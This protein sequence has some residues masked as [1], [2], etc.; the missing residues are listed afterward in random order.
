MINLLN[1]YSSLSKDFHQSLIKAG[2]SYPTFVCQ[3]DGFLP[4]DVQSI[5]QLWID[6]PLEGER[7]YFN[8]LAVPEFWEISA[9][10][11]SGE[12]IDY[13]KKRGR[14]HF[15]KITENR[16]IERVEWF[17]EQGKVRWIDGY[18]KQ[19]IRYKQTVLTKD[20]RM[21]MTTYFDSNGR[22][23]IIYNHHTKTYILMEEHGIQLF[24]TEID[25][26]I[27]TLRAHNV[28]LSNIIYNTLALPFLVVLHSKETKES[29]LIWQEDTRD[30]VPGNMQMILNGSTSTKQ[31]VV[32][33][34][35]YADHLKAL[36]SS[37]SDIPIYDLGYIYS[38][39][40][41]EH[42][43]NEAIIATNS[44]QILHLEEIVQRLPQLKIHV[45]ALTE[46]SAKLTNLN[47]YENIQL[48]PNASMQKI[49]NLY[50]KVGWLLDLNYGNEI[51][52]AVR[53]AFDYQMVIVSFDETTH[54]Q[55]FMY[56]N[57]IFQRTQLDEMIQL[58]KMSF[59]NPE[60]HSKLLV[61]Q[62]L[63]A[64]SVTKSDYVEIFK[65]IEGYF[66]V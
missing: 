38:F 27:Y 22:E 51:V 9:T 54:N 41:N 15:A 32:T 30:E 4:D 21:V 13:H 62:K 39:K 46:M 44:D 66:D 28:D 64:N 25:F 2:F 33:D 58:L 55:K 40:K 5:Y 59:E 34:K 49:R 11:Q 1:D 65:E 18:N 17:D 47:R 10:N 8:E 14:I 7:L 20:Q 36:V 63:A 50:E 57:L 29:T 24:Q 53:S 52:N 19:G 23:K 48:Y 60:I 16:I 31:I 26:I 45:V 61:S 43:I 12:I 56:P 42:L 37:D 3:D 6:N 35:L